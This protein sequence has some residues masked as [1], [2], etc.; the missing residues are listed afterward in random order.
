MRQQSWA[1]NLKRLVTPYN[2]RRAI[3]ATTEHDTV[4]KSIVLLMQARQAKTFL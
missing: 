3:E 4:Q 1:A 2:S